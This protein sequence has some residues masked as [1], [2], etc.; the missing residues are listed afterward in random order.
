MSGF[1]RTVAELSPA[2]RALL[3]L[4]LAEEGIGVEEGMAAAGA[5]ILPQRWTSPEAPLSWAQR[6]LWLIDRMEPGSAAY[7]LPAA[8]RLAG[9]LDLGALAG[10]LGEIVRRH[11]ALR[12]TFR[13]QPD[14]EPVQHVAPPAAAATRPPLVDLGNLPAAVR[15]RLALQLARQEAARPFALATG[16][17][18]RVLLLRL[19]AADHLV[20]VNMHHIVSDGWSLGVF[21]H[22]MTAFYATLLGRRPS[23]PPPLPIQYRDFTLWQR[24]WLSGERLAAALAFWRRQLA[25]APA[26]LLLPTD[27]ART[28]AARPPAGSVELAVPR[29]VGGALLRMAA[30][31]RTTLFV[32]LLAAFQV[33]L[34]RVSGQ[35]D[36][37][38]GT[39]VAGRE[40]L[41]TEGLIGFFVNT[42]AL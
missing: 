7:N 18:L 34:T 25:G 33:L 21:I 17:L 20:M 26:Q 40:R 19:A 3:E 22:E 27:R 12:T 15:E 29:E 35:D 11:E 30:A 41:E 38:V 4:L 6:R 14:G 42:L 5:P 39:P 10:S 8:V 23:P 37:V 32:A 1:G 16:P 24:Q 2:K 31:E 9:R 28:A 13:E 36:L